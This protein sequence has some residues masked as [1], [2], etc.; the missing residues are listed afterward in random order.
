MNFS[1]P[2][3]QEMYPLPANCLRKK[4]TMFSAPKT[5]AKKVPVLRQAKPAL[6]IL[7][8]GVTSLRFIR[9]CL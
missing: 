1:H 9:A 4:T 7:A 3:L 5:C 8:Y 6:R 2:L